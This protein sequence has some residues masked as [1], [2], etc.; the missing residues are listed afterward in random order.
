LNILF[1]ARDLG[2]G[3]GTTF[4][5]QASHGLRARGHRVWVAGQPGGMA[6]RLADAGISPVRVLPSPFCRLQ[7]AY[8]VR[9]HAIDIV[10]ASNVGRGDDAAY[11]RERTGKPFVLSIHGV[12]SRRETKYACFPRAPRLIA[13]DEGVL[14][15]LERL[16]LVEPDKLELVRLPLA[17]RPGAELP[18]D[19]SF[20]VVVTGRLSRRKGQIALDMIRAFDP[21]VETVPGARLTVVGGGSRLGAVRQAARDVN[22]RHGREVVHVTGSLRDPWPFLQG[23]ALVVG[24][25]Y[26]ALEG[27][28]HGKMVLGAGFR[29]FGVVTAE[30]VRQADAANF[31]DSAGE[32]KPTPEALLA[33][34]QE[35]HAG[36]SN[37][38]QREHYCHLDRIVGAE[39]STECV[40][41]RLERIYQAVLA[42]AGQR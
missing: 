37:L 17:R 39:H 6:R 31:G 1:L 14:H 20:P 4:R 11:L 19:G 33:A 2:I 42:E 36:F 15:R 13:F 40:A 38:S 22:R 10:H 29:G 12:L 7:L 18:A 16:Q 30:N 28:I 9:R 24:G 23:A 27:L 5:L 26:A 34:L 41:G 8:L 35:L 32:W 25:G 3:G 21:F